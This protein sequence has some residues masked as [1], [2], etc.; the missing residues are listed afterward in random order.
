ME[1]DDGRPETRNQDGCL[2][3]E[4]EDLGAAVYP[5][6]KETGGQQAGADVEAGAC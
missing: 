1:L 2:Q 6:D 5:Q 4:A 3:E